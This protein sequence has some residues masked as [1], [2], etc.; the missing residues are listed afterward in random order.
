MPGVIEIDE[1]DWTGWETM[2]W[3]KEKIKQ[4]FPSEYVT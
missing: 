4:V 1:V 3:R 2:A